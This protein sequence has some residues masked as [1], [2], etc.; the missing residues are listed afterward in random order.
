MKTLKQARSF[1]FVSKN[2]HTGSVTKEFINS[3]DFNFIF[4][5]ID[6]VL[7]CSEENFD[8]YLN[9]DYNKI[10]CADLQVACNETFNDEFIT[11]SFK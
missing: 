7:T 4:K 5:V 1:D 6:S 10:N 3:T 2:R 8:Y 11:I 9:H